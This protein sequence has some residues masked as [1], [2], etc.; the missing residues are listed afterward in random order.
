MTPD[1]SYYWSSQY[2]FWYSYSLAKSWTKSRWTLFWHWLAVNQ[3]AT[4]GGYMSCR[5]HCSWLVYPWS[6]DTLHKIWDSNMPVEKRL[7]VFGSQL[8]IS[9]SS[10]IMRS[11][12]I[13]ITSPLWKWCRFSCSSSNLYFFY[14]FYIKIYYNTCKGHMLSRGAQSHKV[15]T[16][17]NNIFKKALN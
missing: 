7:K 12:R 6:V 15:L 9:S 17:L 14:L 3:N 16:T 4:R 1:L 11:V 8:H 5:H 10:M 2:S 13:R